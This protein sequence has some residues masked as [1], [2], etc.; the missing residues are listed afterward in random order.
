MIECAV[1]VSEGRDHVVL[2]ALARAAGS[3]LLDLHADPDHHRSVLTL[4]GPDV[5]AAVRDVARRA[6]ET[7]EMATHQGVHPR[8]GSVDVVPFVPLDLD[9]T[10]RPDLDLS[11]ALAARARFAAW[12]GGELD[13]PC[14]F[15]GP[16]R[17][18]PEVRRRAFDDLDPDTGPPRPHPRAGACAVGAR[19]QL[20]AYNV[21]LDTDD[22]ESA[23][24]IATAVRRPGLRA[25]GF[26][27]GGATQVSCNLTDPWHLG[28]ADA[29]DA[30]AGLAAEAGIGVSRAELVGLVPLAVV[31][32]VP[33]GRWR[34]LD[35][36]EDRTLEARLIRSDS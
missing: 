16:E 29:Y 27:V 25:L 26:P 33:H 35:L 9:G 28:P 36:D 5:D 1:N 2:D 10:A 12:A 7:I 21:W 15:Y 8:L 4:A 11:P 13:L 23:R 22:L 32:A 14:F 6:V 30:V 3:C 19:G 34:T 24:A 18:L 17:T 31:Q 20:V